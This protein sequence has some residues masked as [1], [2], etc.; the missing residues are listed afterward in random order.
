MKNLILLLFIFSNIFAVEKVSLQLLWLDQFQFAGYYMA[1]E[2]GFYRDAD[3]DVDIKKYSFKFGKDLSIVDDVISEES[4]YGIGRSNLITEK[5]NGKDVV[6]LASIFQSSPLILLALE[7]S[8]INSIE[9][10]KNK[11]IMLTNSTIGTTS[12]EAMLVSH[13]I[14]LDS[15]Y[16]QAHSFNLDDLINKKTDLMGSYVSNE[17]YILDQKGIKYKMFSPKDEGYDFYSDILFT[18]SK[19]IHLH[20]NRVDKFLKASLKGWQYAFDNIEE[21]V[22]IIFNK[23]NSQNKTREALLYEATKLK[24]LAYYKTENIGE[25]NIEKLQRIYD[26]YK[27]MGKIDIKFDVKEFMYSY[28]KLLLTEEEKS[29]MKDLKTL[30]VHNETFWPPYNYNEY[31]LPKGYSIDYMNL[32]ANK[33][34]LDIQFVSNYKWDE[35]LSMMKNDELDIMLNIVNTE[36]R[37]KYINFTRPYAES[38]PSIYA[39]QTRNDIKSLDDLDGK[40]VSIP[41][42]F[43]TESVLKKHYP[44]IKLKLVNNILESLQDVA[45]ERADA[46]I[47]D[48]AVANYLIKKHG[49]INLKAITD[50]EDK[51]FTSILNIGVRKNLPILQ[52]ILQKGML[53][54][55]DEELFKLR[56]KWFGQKQ[57][58][59]K[60]DL[61]FT[62]I[63]K[64]F[65]QKQKEIKI[66]IDPN[67]APFEYLKNNKYSGI[68]SDYM[69][70]FSKLLNT[71]F[72]LVS[73]HSWY[74]SLLYIKNKKCDVL[75]AAAITIDRLNYINF[76]KP[77]LF[78]PFVLATKK[79]KRNTNNFTYN[80]DKTF[81]M[82]TGYSVI[83]NFKRKYPSIK[84]KEFDS[85]SQGLKALQN[86]EIFGFIDIHST[87]NS[88]VDDVGI[89]SIVVS[90]IFDE[91]I[92]L[93]I[94]IR[95]DKPILL[96]IFQK[97]LTTLSEEDKELIYKKWVTIEYE[98]E[99]DY[100]LVWKVFLPLIIIIFYLW[101]LKLKKEIKHRAIVEKKLKNSVADFT[102]LVNSTIEAIFIIDKEGFCIEANSEAIKLFGFKEKEDY[103]GHHI[104]FI[105]S[106]ND[107]EKV[108]KRIKEKMSFPDKINLIKKDGTVF[109]GLVK[110]ENIRRVY[111]TMRVV[112]IVDLTDVKIKE[113]LLFQQSKMA[114]MGE[115]MSAI[116][117][118]WRQ[119]LN[120]L[121]VLNMQVETKLE[122]MDTISKEDYIPISKN[123]NNQ[124][125]YMSKTIDDFRDFF[126]PSKEKVLFNACLIIQEV[127]DILKPQ[128]LNNSIEFNLNCKFVYVN[129]FVNE[130][131]QVIINIVNNARDAIVL[132]E[133]EKGKIFINVEKVNQKV[134]I[135]IKDNGGGIEK[136]TINKIFNPYFTTKFKSKG[137]GIGLYMSKMII[138]QSM[139]GELSVESSE[140]ETVFTIII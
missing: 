17:P 112:S 138:E 124:L 94:G 58:K 129:G 14:G 117:H 95:N 36:D 59:T 132:N 78:S 114:L 19:E 130:F 126:I 131:K 119:P 92:E 15:K 133:I 46:T 21:S 61:Q 4:T 123:I 56:E 9:E 108:K 104:Y 107:I 34:G 13:G 86:D 69:N 60:K 43:Y 75:P 105:I 110:G 137:T 22:N 27:I 68:S 50:I 116:A 25:L 48:F 5:S 11:R 118:Q 44:N 77:Y 127:Y 72:V 134:K 35:F 106:K 54:I 115:M 93:S 111:Q 128:L 103:I 79:N 122:F 42:S 63:E 23:Y 49:I 125:T 6:A 2:K 16:L 67:W 52:N 120:S 76:T 101:N 57:N 87:I 89:S 66:C 81:G 8:N 40:T 39:L 47:T 70:Y 45:F 99:T 20:P 74:E 28:N 82:V 41:K 121:A 91:K 96:S 29:F 100:S 65:L 30:K 83:E 31:G 55:K 12:I 73:T 37:R 51:R 97:L 98:H 32:L 18:T 71:P 90:H 62:D 1:K 64:N 135:M 80:L 85:I 109:P 136:K 7:S 26:I 139:Q 102:V 88:A 113:T 53:D 140:N 33:L 38:L 10:L 84:I 24:E 3:L